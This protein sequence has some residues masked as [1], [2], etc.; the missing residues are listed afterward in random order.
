MSEVSAAYARQR[1]A[2]HDET[3][4]HSS[5]LVCDPEGRVYIVST[6]AENL[7]LASSDERVVR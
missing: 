3:G 7:Q 5:G 1:R 2:V 4:I 6:A